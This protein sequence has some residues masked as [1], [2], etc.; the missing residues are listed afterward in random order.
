VGELIA[1][2]VEGSDELATYFLLDDGMASRKRRRMLLDPAYN[3]VGLGTA[4]HRLHGVITVV[5]LAE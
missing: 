1:L 4:A 2:G 3:H 5:L